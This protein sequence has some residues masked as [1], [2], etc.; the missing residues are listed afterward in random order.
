M[1]PFS[2][3]KQDSMFYNSNSFREQNKRAEHT[4]Y[5]E[6]ISANYWRNI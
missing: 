3:Y 2:S 4:Y 6:T 5:V 1:A